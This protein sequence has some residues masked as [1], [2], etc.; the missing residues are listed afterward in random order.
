MCRN[1]GACTSSYVSCGTLL[2]TNTIDSFKNIDKK[3]TI[4]SIS[5]KV[6]FLISILYNLLFNI[7]VWEDINSEA[8][9]DDPRLLNRFYLLTFSVS[10]YWLSKASLL[11]AT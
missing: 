8:A 7:Q 11:S 9:I 5:K 6:F 4:E 1:E 3:K 2:N 10:S